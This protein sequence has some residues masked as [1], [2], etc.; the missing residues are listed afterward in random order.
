MIRFIE[1]FNSHAALIA[2]DDLSTGDQERGTC[3][4]FEFV[5]GTYLFIIKRS[6]IFQI[7]REF[8]GPFSRFSTPRGHTAEQ[9][10]QPTHDERTIS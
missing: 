1:A 3:L 4:Q 5:K 8:T 7:F 2:I 10:P 9:I 6:V